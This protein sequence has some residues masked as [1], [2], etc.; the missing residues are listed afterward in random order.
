MQVAHSFTCGPTAII[1][2][3]F[4]AGWCVGIGQTK[5]SRSAPETGGI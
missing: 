4:A 2:P 1:P 3:G 5:T